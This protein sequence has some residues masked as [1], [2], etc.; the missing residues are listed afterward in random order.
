M[1]EMDWPNKDA[2][3]TKRIFQLGW[4]RSCQ[5]YAPFRSVSIASNLATRLMWEIHALPSQVRHVSSGAPTSRGSMMR[6]FVG[7][8][9][10]GQEFGGVWVGS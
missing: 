2:I 1:G 5:T 10:D 6:R 9:W 7:I 8:E 3:T 4:F